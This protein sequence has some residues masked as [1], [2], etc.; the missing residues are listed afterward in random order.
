MSQGEPHGTAAAISDD[1]G[2]LLA[3]T[4]ANQV[5]A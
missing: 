2:D 5:T 1:V 3:A 4:S